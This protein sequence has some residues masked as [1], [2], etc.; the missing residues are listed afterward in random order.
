MAKTATLDFEGKTYTMYLDF[1]ALVA[2]EQELDMSIWALL[3]QF[4]AGKVRIT[5]LAALVTAALL[6]D[7]PDMTQRR[8]GEIIEA[9]GPV[10]IG[11]ALAAA[12]E[13][14][15]LFKSAPPKKRGLPK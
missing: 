2:V 9:V 10:K 12:F 14:S 7:I 8:A 15:S 1:A 4:S 3:E 11:E 13:S 5:Q 6:R